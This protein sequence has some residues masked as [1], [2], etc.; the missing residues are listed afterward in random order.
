MSF[1]ELAFG[2]GGEGRLLQPPPPFPTTITGFPKTHKQ[3]G[4]QSIW[5]KSAKSLLR[6]KFA[7]CLYVSPKSVVRI[8]FI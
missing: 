1:P 8:L 4:N 6:E 3:N 5:P 7:N 2:K